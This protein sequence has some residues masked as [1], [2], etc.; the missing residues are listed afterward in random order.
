MNPR[1]ATAMY[2]CSS[3]VRCACLSRCTQTS[4]RV[5]TPAH[6]LYPTSAPNSHRIA[7]SSSFPRHQASSPTPCHHGIFDSIAALQSGSLLDTKVLVPLHRTLFP[8]V[9]QS[10]GAK[11]RVSQP[12]AGVRT[13]PQ[14]LHIL[15]NFTH[16]NSAPRTSPAIP[17]LIGTSFTFLAC[18]FLLAY[19][20]YTPAAQAQLVGSSGLHIS[21]VDSNAPRVQQ[22]ATFYDPVSAEEREASSA[23]SARVETAVKLLEGGR[24]AQSEGDFEKALML[25]TQVGECACWGI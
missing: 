6:M 18:L 14:H 15:S 1:P 24:G 12:A 21:R 22:S 16:A 17:T 19:I 9:L 8:E 4:G 13:H 3:P 5:S 10:A 11:A 2:T 7:T 25:Y 20:Q 23:F